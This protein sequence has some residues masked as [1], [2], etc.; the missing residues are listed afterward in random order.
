MPE[1]QVSPGEYAFARAGRMV[2]NSFYENPK[3]RLCLERLYARIS[4]SSGELK[5][6][7]A[8]IIPEAEGTPA[9]ILNHNKPRASLLPAETSEALMEKIEDYEL[10]CLVKAREKESFTRRPRSMSYD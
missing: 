1:F 6:N 2:W 10:A 9:A 5:K 8:R 7:P 3:C 4:V